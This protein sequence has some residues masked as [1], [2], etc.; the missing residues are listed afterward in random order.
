MNF[1]VFP[2]IIDENVTKLVVTRTLKF[3]VICA[4]S[5]CILFFARYRLSHAW[6]FGLAQLEFQLFM[7]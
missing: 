4:H 6:P 2:T 7:T 5:L 3:I 1:H